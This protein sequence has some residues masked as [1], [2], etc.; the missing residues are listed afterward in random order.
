MVWSSIV[1]SWWWGYGML[2]AGSEMYKL[3]LT[4]TLVSSLILLFS[5][6]LTKADFDKGWSRG[7]WKWEIRE[8]PPKTLIFCCHYTEATSLSHIV[9]C[10][11][12]YFES[13]IICKKW[14]QFLFISH[15]TSISIQS[16]CTWLSW[17]DG[18]LEAAWIVGGLVQHF[19]FCR[20]MYCNNWLWWGRVW[21][22]NE[23]N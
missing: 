14:S 22:W 23:R 19:K 13:V 1:K 17:T 10:G 20:I 3:H 7:W 2:K 11:N 5:T 4:L 21:E 9:C 18:S 12:I 15:Q 8:H 16:G 6:S